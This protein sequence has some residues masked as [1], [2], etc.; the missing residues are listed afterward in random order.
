MMLMRMLMMLATCMIAVA[1][2]DAKLAMLFAIAVEVYALDWG[3]A[4]VLLFVAV[5]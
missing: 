5:L 1:D 3:L 4:V 2:Y